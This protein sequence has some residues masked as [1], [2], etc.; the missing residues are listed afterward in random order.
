MPTCRFVGSNRLIGDVDVAA[1]VSKAEIEG[2]RE[3]T[4]VGPEA[5]DV[6]G[7]AKS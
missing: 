3:K 5:A 7:A 2:E 1:R 4:D 6:R